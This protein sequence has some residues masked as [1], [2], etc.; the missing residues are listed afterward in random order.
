MK[1]PTRERRVGHEFVGYPQAGA[2]LQQQQPGVEK[3]RMEIEYAAD[4]GASNQA[5][6]AKDAVSRSMQRVILS[7]TPSSSLHNTT[8]HLLPL[9]QA[10]TKRKFCCFLSSAEIQCS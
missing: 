7:T 9:T 10:S 6:I 3:A 2:R 5:R 4:V 8:G 1:K